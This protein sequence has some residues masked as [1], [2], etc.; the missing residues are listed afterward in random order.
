MEGN[1]ASGRGQAGARG[2]GGVW[3]A[4]APVPGVWRGTQQALLA[5][6]PPGRP[7]CPAPPAPPAGLSAPT[8]A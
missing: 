3:E 8:C 4:G 2:P 7:H 5:L 6:S 1:L